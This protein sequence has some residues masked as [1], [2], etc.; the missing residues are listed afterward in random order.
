[1]KPPNFLGEPPHTFKSAPAAGVSTSYWVFRRGISSPHLYESYKAGSTASRSTGSV[2]SESPPPAHPTN[3]DPHS[4]VSCPSG[5][6]MHQGE[7]ENVYE[8]KERDIFRQECSGGSGR[9]EIGLGSRLQKRPSLLYGLHTEHHGC[10]AN[11]EV[12][13]GDRHRGK[14]ACRGAVL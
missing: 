14:R 6:W 1:M 10:G 4:T 13:S 3:N 8:R 11:A 9:E 5:R 12:T 7:G 2:M